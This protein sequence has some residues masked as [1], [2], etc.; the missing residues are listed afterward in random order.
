MT[1]IRRERLRFGLCADVH[2][3]IMHDADE[4]LRVFIERMRREK[5][6]FV[7]QLGDFCRPYDYNRSFMEVWESFPG[8]RFHVHGNHDIDGGF[9]REQTME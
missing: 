6:D 2:K 8:H 4:R 7:L 9:T 5:V 3:D 1:S